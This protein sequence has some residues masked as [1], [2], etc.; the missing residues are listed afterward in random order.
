MFVRSPR[1]SEASARFLVPVEISRPGE[2]DDLVTPAGFTKA[3][4]QAEELCHVAGRYHRGGALVT[5]LARAADQT[6]PAFSRAEQQVL[7]SR[8]VT[9]YGSAFAFGRRSSM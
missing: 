7:I 9:T 1:R 5:R 4:A 6:W 2:A 3:I 8:R